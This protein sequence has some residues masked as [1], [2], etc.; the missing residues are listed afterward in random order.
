MPG[1]DEVALALPRLV[2]LDDLDQ[3]GP[4]ARPG[5]CRRAR[6]SRA[7]A[8]R[9]GSTC[10]AAGRGGC[11]AGRAR[12]CASVRRSSMTGRRRRA[13]VGSHRAELQDRERVAVASDRGAGGTGPAVRSTSSTASATSSTIGSVRSE[14]DRGD[15]PVEQR[16]ADPRVERRRRPGERE[17]RDRLRTAAATASASTVSAR[18]HAD[19]LGSRGPGPEGSCPGPGREDA[20]GRAGRV[21]RDFG[22]CVGSGDGLVTTRLAHDDRTRQH[23]TGADGREAGDVATRERQARRLGGGVGLDLGARVRRRGPGS[24]GSG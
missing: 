12:S 2:A 1:P 4:R 24:T 5:S 19:V 16:L 8:A 11:G 20:A 13:P 23:R 22:W 3:L 18:T 14:E 17:V 10:A 7:G 9:R 15:R 21:L 6:R